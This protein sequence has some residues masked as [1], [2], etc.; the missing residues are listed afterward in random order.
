MDRGST[1]LVIATV[2][3]WWLTV[4]AAL[5]L[6]VISFL[7][8][9]GCDQGI[10]EQLTWDAAHDRQLLTCPSSSRRC[11]RRWASRWWC[12]SDG[13][14]GSLSKRVTSEVHVWT[15]EV[16]PGGLSG[17]PVRVQRQAHM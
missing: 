3:S 8:I 6:D 9:K 7:F 12:W 5:G 17:R 1:V 15:G 14:V 10:L 2:T 11:R 4:P 13:V 16:G